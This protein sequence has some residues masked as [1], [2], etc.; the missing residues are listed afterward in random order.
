MKYKNGKL[1]EGSNPYHEVLSPLAEVNDLN[2]NPV[3]LGIAVV[4]VRANF[5]GVLTSPV[6][7]FMEACLFAITYLT[8]ALV[9]D[10]ER[11]IAW[12][13]N[14]RRVDNSYCFVQLHLI[15]QLVVQVN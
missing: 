8:N 9:F 14:A 1:K 4:D 2:V 11:L 10:S 3:L 6:Q 12:L 15:A 5:E 7:M 13:T